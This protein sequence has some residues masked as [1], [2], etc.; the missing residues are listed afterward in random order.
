MDDPTISAAVFAPLLAIVA[1]T[2]K[3]SILIL[4]LVALSRALRRAPAATR[5][6]MWSAGLIAILA[7]PLLSL[8]SPWRLGV[9]LGS[10]RNTFAPADVRSAARPGTRV[11]QDMSGASRAAS[12]RSPARRDRIEIASSPPVLLALTLIWL[13]GVG[14]FGLRLVADWRAVRRIVRGA[15]L[16]S[17][18]DG[19]DHAE[20]SAAPMWSVGTTRVVRSPNVTV[21]FTAGAI[22]PVIVLPWTCEAWSI[23][24]R[25]AVLTHELAHVHRRDVA[26]HLLAR[27]TCALH[28]FNPL[29][30]LLARRLREESE[31]AADD[32]VLTLGMRPSAYAS[33]LLDLVRSRQGARRLAAAMSIARESELEGRLR[34]IL[35][36]DARRGSPSRFATAAIVAAVGLGVAPLAA[37]APPNTTAGTRLPIETSPAAHQI[38]APAGGLI[39]ALADA[40]ADVRRVAAH[41]LGESGD[42]SAVNALASLLAEDAVAEVRATAA[43]ALGQMAD[44]RALDALMHAVADEHADVRVAAV[45]ALNELGDRRAL[46]ALLRALRDETPAARRMAARTLGDLDLSVVPAPLAA[47]ASDPD[48]EVRRFAVWAIGRI[49]GA[50]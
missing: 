26:L 37:L 19:A 28:W 43:W 18:T 47:A 12:A 20:D 23:E 35:Q 1:T 10:E 16:C 42:T 15:E 33:H 38:P 31:R 46:P 5:R 34:A 3:G 14:L 2:V 11:L 49:G 39:G 9:P 45:W 24:R 30:W 32:V 7:L 25:R 41:A 6:A 21:A 50:Q 27:S 17:L 8:G 4:L 29:V 40:D 44:P 13:T 36:P 22:R 48:P